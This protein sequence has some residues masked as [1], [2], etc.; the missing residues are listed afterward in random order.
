MELMLW[1]SLILA[2]PA[3][4]F[5]VHRI[6][7]RGLLSTILSTVMFFLLWSLLWAGAE[8]LYIHLF[9]MSEKG[10]DGWRYIY[11]GDSGMGY[12][13]GFVHYHRNVVPVLMAGALIGAVWGGLLE[14]FRSFLKISRV[15]NG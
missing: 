6:R 13:D 3:A 5:V 8:E 1:G 9:T 7:L 11:P 12:A 4:G 10:A 2:L 15:E 14:I